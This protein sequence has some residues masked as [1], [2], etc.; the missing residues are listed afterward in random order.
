MRLDFSVSSDL[1]LALLPELVLTG[2]VLILLLFVAWRH[3]TVRDLRWAA[4]ISAVALATTAVAVW[5]L[6]WNEAKVVRVA[7]IA[8]DDFRWVT[9]WL[10]SSAQRVSCGGSGTRARAPRGSRR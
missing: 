9:D 3:K 4:G 8:V 7:Q 1:L 2:W 5:W 6:W 10:A